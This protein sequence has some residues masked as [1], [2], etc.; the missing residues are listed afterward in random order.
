[1]HR[2]M[3]TSVTVAVF[4][5]PLRDPAVVLTKGRRE[6]AV[7]IRNLPHYTCMETV[8]RRYSNRL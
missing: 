5:A 6:I 2:W 7:A 3:V 1:M 8:D 4:A